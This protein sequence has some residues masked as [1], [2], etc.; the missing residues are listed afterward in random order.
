MP[1][2]V[3]IDGLLGKLADWR[4]RHAAR[5]AL[6]AAG[7][8]AAAEPVL[9]LVQDSDA[10]ENTR[11]AALAILADWKYAPANPV[12]L[13]LLRND[14]HLRGEACRTLQA[15]TGM[16]IGE[17]AVA[18]NRF[19]NGASAADVA[20]DA[21][22]A[23][24][25]AATAAAGGKVDLA[26]IREAL[27]GVAEEISW[28]EPGYAYIRCPCDGGRKQQVVVCFQTDPRTGDPTVLAYTESGE[29]V[30]GAA[31]ALQRRNAT[32]RFG[33]VFRLEKNSE[34]REVVACRCSVPRSQARP[35][36]LR[37]IILHLAHEADSLENEL[38]GTDVM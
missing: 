23:A 8:A 34:G 33:A 3:K 10:S 38:H 35:E 36:L 26:L 16:E 7:P 25:K 15:I 18:W 31:D 20:A 1:H 24:G 11:W 12:L 22:E 27:A 30:P 14:P 9:A 5:T 13:E 17:D 21:A 4:T 6:A 29:A 2:T 19:L 32:V 37:E 28:E